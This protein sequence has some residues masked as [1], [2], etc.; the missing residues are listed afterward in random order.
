MGGRAIY[1]SQTARQ[2]VSILIN[3]ALQ[4]GALQTNHQNRLNGFS[5]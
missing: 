4:P 3:T 5:F 2:V 1:E